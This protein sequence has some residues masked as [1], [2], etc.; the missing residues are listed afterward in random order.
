MN[1]LFDLE[2]RKHG[3]GL[4][5]FA[6]YT[7]NYDADETIL[8]CHWHS[9][10]EF[11]TVTEGAGVFHLG[12]E[13]Y[14]VNRGEAII[15]PGGC[16]HSGRTA[17]GRN[18]SFEASVFSADLINSAVDDRI[19]TR[20]IDPV[21]KGLKYRCPHIQ[22][23][24]E[25]ERMLLGTIRDLYRVYRNRKPFYELELKVK[26]LEVILQ[27]NRISPSDPSVE[28]AVSQGNNRAVK[29]ALRYIHSHYKKE[30]SLDELAEASGFSTAHFTR[31]FTETVHMPPISYLNFFRIN[32]SLELL[33]DSGLS[34]AAIA[35][36]SGYS[37]VNY[38]IRC[39]RKVKG[40]TPGQF[41][42]QG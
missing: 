29:E 24:T 18:C 2:A 28:P 35:E 27:L 1:N 39:F 33:Q 40:I 5:P 10:I 15:I 6:G 30:I 20:Q 14:T 36:Q 16:L 12:E 32:R 9:E 17:P 7:M 8:D 11:L 26:V 34:L 13:F 37:S 21:L 19:Q 4:F 41:R 22:G 23:E 25:D 31:L 3:T 38:Y 42:K